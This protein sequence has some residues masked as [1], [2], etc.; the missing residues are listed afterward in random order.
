MKYFA[1]L[2]LVSLLFSAPAFAQVDPAFY[3][4]LDKEAAAIEQK[5]IEWRRH[6]HENPELSNREFNTGK[7]IAEYLKTLNLEVSHPMAKTGVVAILKGAKPADLPLEQPSRFEFIINA[8][9]A[10]ALGLTI[11]QSLLISADKVIE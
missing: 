6:F 11:P 8:K 4:L 3:S 2:A 10:K 1:S 5:V 7:Y 9:A